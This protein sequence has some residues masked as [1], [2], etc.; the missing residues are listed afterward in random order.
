MSVDVKN[1]NS[2]SNKNIQ[3]PKLLKTVLFQVSGMNILMLVAFLIVMVIVIGTMRS[4][5]SSSITMFDHMMNLTTSEAQLKSDVMALYDQATGYV[6]A[7][8][9]ETKEALLPNIESAKT[10]IES[11][12][13]EL[14]T[15]FTESKNE[16]VLDD[17][18]EIEGQYQRLSALI[19]SALEYSDNGNTD[20]AYTTLFDKAEI[21][22]I[23]I[24]HA[25]EVIDE[26]IETSAADTTRSMQIN[27]SNGQKVALVGTIVMVLFILANLMINYN[28]VVRKI[29][30]ISNEVNAIINDIEDGKGDLTARIKTKTES[31]LVY[32]V[33][34][35]NH[36]IS[37]LQNVMKDVK[38]GATVLTSSSE[39]VNNQM[40]IANDN[41]T[42]TSAA[43]EQLSAGMDT[44][45]N[46]VST[47]NESVE[48]VRAAAQ[49][50]TDE[51]RNG[52]ETAN[53]IKAEADELKEQVTRKKDDT[54]RKME[55]L[56][57]VLEASV[58]DSEKV[59]QINELTNVIL[60]ISSQ[61]NLLALNASIEAA[62]AGEA[63]KGFAVV[64]TEISSLA[65][66]SRQ[67]AGNIQEISNEVTSAVKSLASNAQEVLDFINT[68]VLADYDEFV[69]TGEKYEETADVMTTMLDKFS[70]KAENLDSIMSEMVRSI[71]MITTSIQESTEAIG[72]S[73]QNSTE[74]VGSFKEISDAM[75]KNTEVTKQLDDTTA[76]FVAL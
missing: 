39:E 62:R 25:T 13:S 67:T 70:D 7:D 50:I 63:G 61:T 16:Q 76:K 30:S 52:T 45:S 68:T 36:F 56:A 60:D 17:L 74:M 4:S 46:T 33:N 72:M 58:K 69:K 37:T 11:D 44:V 15:Y 42:N 75:A 65:E 71:E 57:S 24:F 6:S 21:Q 9:T 26:A 64:A 66:N 5:T 14:K 19:D 12:I 31:E 53:N 51:A 32:I 2:N 73:A 10:A 22:K 49:D 48:D 47:I 43:L 8:A 38:N 23:A 20:V 29:K 27:L 18:E 41:I 55:S 54:G 28:N 40:S 34:G 59:G 1:V 3:K 35:I